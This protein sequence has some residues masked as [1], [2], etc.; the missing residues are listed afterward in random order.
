MKVTTQATIDI[1]APPAA[2][3]DD[4]AADYAGFA[5][6]FPGYGLI[7][8]IEKIT[9][10]EGEQLTEGSIRLIHNGDGSVLRERVEVLRRPE[11]HV[12]VLSG[13]VFPFSLLVREATGAWLF[14]P[15]GQGTRVV[16]NYDFELTSFL[17]WPL[18][19]PIIWLFFR[20]AMR[21]SLGLIKQRLGGG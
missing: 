11:A 10:E 15:A 5:A 7:P 8:K 14:E 17:A 6:V 2:V 12:Y 1:A 19:A 21:R 9:L 13:F 3:F 18:A 16:W 20:G 4:A